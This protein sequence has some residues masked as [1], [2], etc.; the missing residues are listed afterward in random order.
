MLIAIFVEVAGKLFK[1]TKFIFKS[2][3]LIGWK[4]L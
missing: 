1:G 2:L 4:L 3:K